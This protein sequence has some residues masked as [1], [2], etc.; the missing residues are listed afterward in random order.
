[1][2]VLFKFLMW[3][4]NSVLDPSPE[5]IAEGAELMVDAVIP[6]YIGII[7]WLASLGGGIFVAFLIIGVIWLVKWSGTTYF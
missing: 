6:W 3:T 5:N 7:G 2:P 4:A 1:M